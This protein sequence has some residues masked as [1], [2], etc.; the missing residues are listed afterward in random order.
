MLEGAGTLS[1]VDWSKWNYADAGAVKVDTSRIYLTGHS[2]GGD[3]ALTA[4]AVSSGPSMTNTFSA[5]SIWN[6][7]FEG[8]VEQA[9]LRS[10]GEQQRRLDRPGLLPYHAIVV[11]SELVPHDHRGGHRL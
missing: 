8:R 5:A 7:C 6:G 2:Q 9:L 4:L 1:A 10:P 11:G 3:A